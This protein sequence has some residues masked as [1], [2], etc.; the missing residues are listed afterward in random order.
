M[1][2][3]LPR[4]SQALRRPHWVRQALSGSKFE[5]RD[6]ARASDCHN[7][8]PLCDSV[9]TMGL[10]TRQKAGPFPDV[11][12][13]RYLDQFHCDT[14]VIMA[15]NAGIIFRRGTEVP[16]FATLAW[17][18]L[19]AA[20]GC[21]LII[22]VDEARHSQK[23]WIMNLVWP[24]TALYFSV[25]AL[26]VYFR[27]GRPMGRDAMGKMSHMNMDDATEQHDPT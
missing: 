24:I 26:W 8:T 18:S 17:T 6:C 2:P 4:G 23:M 3:R 10:S 5:N 13:P 1:L 12:C 14:G 11:F 15:V 20:F 22:A 16:M 7:R 21:A 27:I 19:I 25:F 9:C